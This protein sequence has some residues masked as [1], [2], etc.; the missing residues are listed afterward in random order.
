MVNWKNK[1]PCIS[2]QTTYRIQNEADL[3]KSYK[4]NLKEANE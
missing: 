4:G 1:I 2:I 3:T